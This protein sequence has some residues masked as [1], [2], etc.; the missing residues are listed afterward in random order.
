MNHILTLQSLE[1]QFTHEGGYNIA[2]YIS[3]KFRK[4]KAPSISA[5]VPKQD[6]RYTIG[7]Q[8]SNANVIDAWLN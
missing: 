7:F 4:D 8:P 6:S 1:E 5:V 3:F 2:R